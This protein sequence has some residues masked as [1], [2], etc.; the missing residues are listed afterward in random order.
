MDRY[1]VKPVNQA[2]ENKDTSV[3][4]TLSYGSKWCFSIY[5][6]PDNQDTLTLMNGLNVFIIHKYHCTGLSNI[7]D[8]QPITDENSFLQ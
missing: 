8:I 1:T 2:L 5:I 6:D 7:T 4:H 3:I